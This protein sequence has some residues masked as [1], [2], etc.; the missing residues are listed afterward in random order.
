[1]HADIGK[2]LQCAGRKDARSLLQSDA[3]KWHFL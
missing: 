2:R 3:G 1:M